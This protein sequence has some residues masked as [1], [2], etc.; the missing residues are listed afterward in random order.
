MG[1]LHRKLFRDLLHLR[2][3]VIAVALVV[4]CGVASYVSMR[5]VYISLLSTQQSY[6]REYRFA[7][8]FAQLKRAPDSLAVRL[9]NIPGVAAVQ[10]RV[11][12]DV[13]LDVPGLAEPAVGRLVSI[14]SRRAPML[15]DLYLPRGRY[16]EP[17]ND[18]EVIASEAFVVANKLDVGSSV[19]AVMNGRWKRLRIVGIAISPE[20]IYEIRGG[21]SVF[22]DNRRFGVLWMDHEVLGY[23]FNMDGAFNDVALATAPGANLDDVIG[24]VDQLLDTYGGLGA[25]SREDQLSHSFISDEIAQNRVSSNIIPAI[26]LGVAALLVHIVLSR[27]VKTQRMQVAIIKA[28]GYSNLEVGLHYLEL[29]FISVLGGIALGTGVGWYFGAKL[30]AIYADFY[31]FPVLQFRIGPVI[32]IQAALI[33]LAGAALGAI[34]SVRMAVSLPPAEAMRPEPPARYRLGLLEKL[35]VFRGLSPAVRMIIRNLERRPVRAMLS[36]FAICCSVA[37]LVIDFGLFDSMSRM[38]EI[39]FRSVQ[40]EDVMVILNEPRGSSVQFDLARLP[41]VMVSEP[42]R[43]VAARLRFEHHTHRTLILGLEKEHELRRVL[44]LKLNDVPVPEKGILLTSKLAGLLGVKPG[45]VITVEVLEGKRPVRQLVV[46]GLADEMLGLSAYMQRDAL[47][48]LMQ[49]GSTISGSFL[50][51]DGK[52]ES[53]LY[54]LLKR[55]PGVGAVAIRQAALDSF[56]ETINRSLALSLTTLI[57]FASIIAIGM[58][59]NGARIALSERANELASL[60]ILGFTRREISVLLLGEQA[61]LTLMAIPFGFLLGYAAC[62]L[63]ARNLQTELYR[64]P[65]WIKATT[66]AWSFIIV[67]LSAF[68]SALLVRRKLDRLDLVA[69]LKSRE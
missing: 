65:L 63:L 66:Y 60:R 15:N 68:F 39:Q 18:D 17:G 48:Q 4:A 35:R 7:D 45:Q 20:Y 46:S 41:G 9:E 53:E 51:V 16:I 23:A 54:T 8:V 21:G 42:F 3:Q 43:A 14:P 32:M 27:L 36:V 12:M 34:D 29:A 58:I 47:N 2:G 59:Y 28:F 56:N 52:R 1:T 19:Q 10:T 31:R 62:A 5:S 38:I 44:D 33:T 69:V 50:Q 30:T 26:F 57:I 37:I 22:P 11:V 24:R 55:T 25:Y 49:E 64:L 67:V 61:A 40:R 6:Y 13:I